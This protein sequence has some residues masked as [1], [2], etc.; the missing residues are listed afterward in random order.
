MY[1][2]ALDRGDD[3]LRVTGERFLISRQGAQCLR[4]RK[5]GKELFYLSPDSKM[6]AFADKTGAQYLYTLG[7]SDG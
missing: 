1:L 7:E 5:D 3:S 6:I 2:Q 4:W